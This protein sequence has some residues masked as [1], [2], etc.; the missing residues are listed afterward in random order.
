MNGESILAYLSQLSLH[1]DREW[2]HANKSAY[3]E[4]REAFEELVRVLTLELHARD[5]S[6]PLA[7]PRTL[8]FKLMRD[9][10]F[11]QDKSPYNPAFRSRR[12]A[13]NPRRLFHQYKTGKPVDSR[14]R[15]ICRYV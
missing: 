3:R 10:R 11:S 15:I 2:F 6:I 5:A 12:E 14:R 8:T 9:T 4:A 7:D 1:N 13:T